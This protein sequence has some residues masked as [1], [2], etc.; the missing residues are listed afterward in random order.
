MRRS[1]W[2]GLGLAALTVALYAPA[3]RSQFLAFDDP[4]YATANRH[5]RA[6]LTLDG[7][8]WAFRSNLTNVLLHAANSGPPDCANN[9]SYDAR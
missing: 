4:V 2:I 7:V 8:A 1:L 9:R 6:G 3:L 5:V